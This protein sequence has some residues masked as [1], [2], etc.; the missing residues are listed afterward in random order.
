ML[1][2]RCEGSSVVVQRPMAPLVLLLDTRC[3]GWPEFHE[4]FCVRRKQG[5][6]SRRFRQRRRRF[7]GRRHGFTISKTLSSHNHMV[8]CDRQASAARTGAMVL[9]GQPRLLPETRD[10]IRI[11]GISLTSQINRS[12][13]RHPTLSVGGVSPYLLCCTS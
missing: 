5:F 13:Q 4:G 10:P 7:Q 9:L 8:F 1:V 2:R 6:P 11:Q 12:I 3:G